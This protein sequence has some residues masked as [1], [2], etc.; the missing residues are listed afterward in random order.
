[1]SS[2]APA[3]VLGF[4]A[5]LVV[6]TSLIRGLSAATQF[7]LVFWIVPAEFGY[8][9]AANASIGVLAGLANLGMVNAYLAGDGVTGARLRRET[10]LANIGLAAL[11][12]LIAALYLGS[13]HREVALL[14][15]I[16]SLT[17]PL[18]GAADVHHAFRVQGR[19]VRRILFSQVTAALAKLSVGVA[20]AIL[21]E[22]AVALA[23]AN[24]AF[25]VVSLALM[26][27]RRP[28]HHHSAETK[29]DES[30][31]IQTRAKWV[32]NRWS[33]NLQI[34]AVILVAQFFASPATLGLFYVGYQ[35][36]IA[37]QS[38]IAAPLHRVFL[39]SLADLPAEDRRDLAARS[40]GPVG[41]SALMGA[42]LLTLALVTLGPAL[43]AVWVEAIPIAIVL[44]ALLPTRLVAP[45]VDSELLTAGR[46][47]ASTTLYLIDAAGCMV[48]AA[49]L[50]SQGPT[51]LAVGIFCWKSSVALVRI[52]TLVVGTRSGGTSTAILAVSTGVLA[53]AG[54]L[55]T[56][57]QA[58]SG[59]ILLVT[60]AVW[61]R[62]G[63][64]DR[65][66][67]KDDDVE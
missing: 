20:V 28:P 47:A 11:G 55:G 34:H 16:A 33:L 64:R 45:V 17:I 10:G 41:A 35:L 50:V 36:V 19:D 5:R 25:W 22:S 4:A 9:A 37:V 31:S 60:G 40:V 29:A 54:G 1:M 52:L 66:A 26:Y 12:C 61:L 48:L 51:W 8:W 59:L 23:T 53:T 44:A 24:A 30:L 2:A 15:L 62:R 43:P 38:L 14:A 7:L 49:I 13:G 56:A 39:S 42:A 67:R 46:W 57:A 18:S 58:A 63:L 21:T 65:R 32:A 6:G 3:G 27:R